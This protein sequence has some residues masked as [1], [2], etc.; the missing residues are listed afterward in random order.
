MKLSDSLR[1]GRRL[2]P[3]KPRAGIDDQLHQRTYNSVKSKVHFRLVEELD[4][5]TVTDLP[6]EELAAA[7][8]Q[9]LQE[10]TTVEQLPLNQTERSMLVSDLMN[11]IMGLGPLEPLMADPTVQDILVNGHAQVYVEKSGLLTLSATRFRDDEHLMQIID[12]IVTAVGR[13][14]DESSPMVDARLADGSR[15]N[16]VIPPLSL[17]GPVLSI[18]KFAHQALTVE[19]L[20]DN[21]SITPEIYEYM[22]AAIKSRLNILISGG[23][24]V[25]KTTFLNILSGFIPEAERIITIEDSAELRLHQPHVISLEA[26]PGN[27]E[28]RGSV[29]MTDLVRNSLRMRPDRIIVGEARGGEV[30]DMLQA[31]NTGHPGSMSTIHAN[32]PRNALSR[33]QVMADMGES[34]FSERALRGLIASAINVIVQLNRLADG[35]RRVTSISEVTGMQ[36]ETVTSQDVFV[37][38]QHGI[39]A[40]GAVYGVFQGTGVVSSYLDHF[41]SHGINLNTDIFSFQSHVR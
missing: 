27:T 40:R 18:R 6:R 36:G 39:G 34:S 7:V 12:R 11:E 26:R 30:M 20:I 8:R 31:M 38:E 29:T 9:T 21:Q 28:G 10:I 32:S 24:G 19:A 4:L 17:C 16:V 5:A 13:R 25:G 1:A 33:I 23:T 2:S 14:V 22:R 3:V 15:V 41:R 35:K 37:F